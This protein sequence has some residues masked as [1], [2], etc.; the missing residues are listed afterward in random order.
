MTTTLKHTDVRL[1][2]V[3]PRWCNH[4]LFKA[5]FGSLIH[6]ACI[7]QP[8]KR[9]F[10]SVELGDM[11]QR[12][13]VNKL[14]ITAAQVSVHIRDFKHDA[15][16]LRS[17]RG[18]DEIIHHTPLNREDEEWLVQNRMAFSVSDHSLLFFFFSFPSHSPLVSLAN[19]FAPVHVWYHR[20]AADLEVSAGFTNTFVDLHATD[21]QPIC[22]VCSHFILFVHPPIV[23]LQEHQ[24][25]CVGA[26]DSNCFA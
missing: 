21:R 7:V 20:G 19:F 1:T 4:V 18:L 22:R 3:H 2:R 11:V 15:N 14:H 23:R 5:F 6:A 25:E 26:L 9:D 12:A 10:C 17:I 16:L 24:R 13:G 8:V